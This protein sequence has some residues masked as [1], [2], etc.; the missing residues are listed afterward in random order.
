MALLNN[1]VPID[2]TACRLQSLDRASQVVR[3]RWAAGRIEEDRDMDVREMRAL[4]LGRRARPVRLHP[5][6]R[7]P[8]RARHQ[9]GSCLWSAPKQTGTRSCSFP[10]LP[11]NFECCQCCVFELY[12]VLL[13]L[14]RG[15]NR[16]GFL[17][18]ISSKRNGCHRGN[19]F[20]R[21]LFVHFLNKRFFSDFRQR[22]ATVGALLRSFTLVVIQ[23]EGFYWIDSSVIAT[24]ISFPDN[25]TR[26]VWFDGVNR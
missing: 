8:Q 10:Q 21:V 26:K 11:P 13:D 3:R 6:T 4:P 2:T 9:L 17:P 16:F 25:K 18:W 12:L 22:Y 24:R 23:S 7:L 19:R 20:G 1:F 15:A 14:I 5:G